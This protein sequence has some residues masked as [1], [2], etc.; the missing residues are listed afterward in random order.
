MH[1]EVA[2]Q[3]EA[4]LAANLHTTLLQTAVLFAGIQ[5]GINNGE[6]CR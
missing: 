2:E 5:V 4:N 1:V 6:I 3:D